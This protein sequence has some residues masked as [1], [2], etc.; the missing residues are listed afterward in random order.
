MQGHT[1]GQDPAPPECQSVVTGIIPV[2]RADL[3]LRLA[4]RVLS[5]ECYVYTLHSKYIN[6]IYSRI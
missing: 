5:L 4:G 3:A 1:E 2:F 6:I